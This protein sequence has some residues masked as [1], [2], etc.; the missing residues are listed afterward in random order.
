[1]DAFQVVGVTLSPLRGRTRVYSSLSPV[2]SSAWCI[3]VWPRLCLVPPNVCGCCGCSPPP[4]LPPSSRLVLLLLLLADGRF[5]WISCPAFLAVESGHVTT[6]WP[7]EC[8][9]LSRA[10]RRRAAG[11]LSSF[12]LLLGLECMGATFNYMNKGDTF[13]MAEQ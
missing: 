2:P 10:F 7:K 9:P 11:H 5:L 4:P 8:S 6:F 3:E 12:L 1:M 13:R